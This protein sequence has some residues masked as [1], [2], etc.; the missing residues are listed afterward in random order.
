MKRA[1]RRDGERVVAELTQG[2]L[3]LLRGLQRDLRTLVDG[4][5]DP[6]DPAVARLFP[7]AVG[8]EVDQLSVDLLH[9]SL[10]AGRLRGLD[11][12][13]EVLDRAESTRRRRVT[14]VDDEPALFLGVL[15]DLRLA[16]GARIGIATLDEHDVEEADESLQYSLAV[17]HHLG[18]WVDDL[19]A[20]LDPAAA[21]WQDDY[22]GPV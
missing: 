17:M 14:L 4:G 7:P 21:A 5:L 11:A 1:F 12:V 10:L 22:D 15:N 2:E 20:V 16:I 8:D 19:V 18:M 6:T 9:A 13:V 3:N